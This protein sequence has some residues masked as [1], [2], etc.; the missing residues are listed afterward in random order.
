MKKALCLAFICLPLIAFTQ[1]DDA[2]IKFGQRDSLVSKVLNESRPYWVYLPPSYNDKTI[3]PIHYPVL[4]VLDGDVNFKSI[5]SM[6]EILSSGVNSTYVLPEMIIVGIVHLDRT[7]ELTPTH[8]LKGVDGNDWADYLKTSGNG[9][10]FLK[11]MRDELIPRIEFNYRTFPFRVFIGHSFGGLAV[12]NALLTM[13]Q[14]FNAYLATDPS[15]WWDNQI[16]VTRAKDHFKT[17]E[18]K[19]KYLYIA[20]ANSSFADDPRT[21]PSADAAKELATILETQNTSGLKWNY[22]YY[23]NDNHGS[24]GFAAEY[25]ALRFFFEGYFAKFSVIKNAEELKDQFK[26]FSLESGVNF[27]PPEKVVNEFA[28]IS[29]FFKRDEVVQGFYQL[30]LDNY[31]QSPS[32]NENMGQVWLNKGEKEKALMYFE[33]SLKLNPDNADLARRIKIL[34]DELKQR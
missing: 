1:S 13:P 10:N 3:Q 31:P 4:Y 11:F 5:C 28:G 29:S 15:L 7:K 33:R 19:V 22:K 27:A 8:T 17:A 9:D 16:L 21:I 6:V 26:R 24:V 18:L 12:I 32:A 30:N 14:T 25:D 23:Q 20:Q 34:K 2:I